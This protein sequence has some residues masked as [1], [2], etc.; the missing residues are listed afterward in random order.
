MASAVETPLRDFLTLNADQ[1]ADL[2]HKYRRADGSVDLPVGDAHGV[3]RRDLMRIRTRMLNAHQLMKDDARAR[4][5]D[6]DM[7]N[8]LTMIETASAAAAFELLARTLGVSDDEPDFDTYV[9]QQK[10]YEGKV[11]R[12]QGLAEI[13][14]NPESLRGP[15]IEGE[16]QH[17]GLEPDD[18]S[19]KCVTPQTLG[20][21][22]QQLAE[23]E[24]R[25][26]EL[27]K[28]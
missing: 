18:G 2:M 21:A 8:K 1:M 14:A 27:K 20:D 6:L 13:E 17:I 23:A 26:K 11:W 10:A 9:E 25:S 7:A 4:P 24:K 28:G 15:D 12:G 5:F 3:S 19:H 16:R 22:R